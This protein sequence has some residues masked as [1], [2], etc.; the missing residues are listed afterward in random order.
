V[1]AFCFVT[2]ETVKGLATANLQYTNFEGST[3]L[4]GNAFS[5]AD[6]T[7]AKLSDEIKEFKSLEIFKET[8]QNAR[9]IFFAMLL[10]CCKSSCFFS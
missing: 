9:K 2:L 1:G 4:L 7:G 6:V 3:G 8:S 5:Q 10:G